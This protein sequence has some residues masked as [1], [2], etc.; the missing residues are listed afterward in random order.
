MLSPAS[1]NL[2]LSHLDAFPVTETL[3][4]GSSVMWVIKFKF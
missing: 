1:K 3:V 4:L 2:K